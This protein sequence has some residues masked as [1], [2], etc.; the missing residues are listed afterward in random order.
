M[1]PLIPP[2][3]GKTAPRMPAISEKMLTSLNAGA[4]EMRMDLLNELW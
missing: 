2:E 1:R 4:C 3:A